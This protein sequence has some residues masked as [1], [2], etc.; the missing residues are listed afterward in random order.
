[1][2]PISPSSTEDIMKLSKK[3]RMVAVARKILIVIIVAVVILC[4]GWFLYARFFAAKVSDKNYI[5]TAT[6]AGIAQSIR[7]N[8]EPTPVIVRYGVAQSIRK[9]SVT[10]TSTSKN[11][12]ITN[13]TPQSEREAVLKSLLRQ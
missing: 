11:G 2:D 6:K 8:S 12:E 13:T 3:N 9:N 1:M 7:Q 4:I 5:D 10:A